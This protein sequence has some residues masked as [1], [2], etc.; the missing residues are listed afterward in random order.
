LAPDQ[1][2]DAVQL[3]A[4]ALLH[5]S[6]ELCEAVMVEGDELRVTDVVPLTVTDAERVM[7]PPSPVHARVYVD[8]S[9]GD[10]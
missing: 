2:P 7:S 9:V 8:V 5:V 4:F 10:N 6:V 3:S 1:L